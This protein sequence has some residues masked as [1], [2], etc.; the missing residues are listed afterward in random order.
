M[1][2]TPPRATRRPGPLQLLRGY[3]IRHVQTMTG[4]LGRLWQQPLANLMTVAVIGIALALPTGLHL[5]VE[6]GRA[7]SGNWSSTVDVSVY[8]RKDTLP[9][10]VVAISE[11]LAD[12]PEVASVRTVPAEQALVEFAELSGFG[13][14]IEALENNPLPDTLVITPGEGYTDA[15]SLVAL[16]DA[17]R[18]VDGADIVQVDTDWVRRFNAILDLIRRT[19]GLSA[20]L[21]ALGVVL[22]VGNTIRLDIE[23]RRSEIEVTK[24]VGGSD[25]FVR[26]P[27]L[28][29]GFWYGFGGGLLALALTFISLL[30]LRGPAARLAGHYGSGY[31]LSGLGWSGTATLLAVSALLGWAGSWIA[32]T[33]HLRQIEP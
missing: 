28:Y 20:F 2:A 24:L 18:L 7:M 1:A 31:T 6:N 21:L 13:E 16:A 17:L 15:E 12:W 25:A 26:R 14:A 30:M 10:R 32:T 23:N 8:L 22:I 9:E 33:R 11:E 29:S 4:A 19:V 3:V 5:L 27:F